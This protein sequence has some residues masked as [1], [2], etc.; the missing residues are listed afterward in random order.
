M[1]FTRNLARSIS[2]G[3]LAAFAACSVFEPPDAVDASA[4]GGAAGD[5]SV[6]VAS[7]GQAGSGGK[8]GSGGSS[9]GGAGGAG[10]GSG[11]VGGDAGPGGP[12][13]PRTTADGCESAG[14][15]KATDRPKASDPG[16][17]VGPIYLATSRMRFGSA[18]DDDALSADKDAWT[19]IGF[20]MDESCT[21][22]PTCSV[23]GGLVAEH[24]CKNSLL[25][26]FDGKQCRDNQ[27]GKLLPVA[28]LSPQVGPLFG[29]T[30]PNWNCAMHRGE[31]AVIFKVSDYNGKP[32]DA[33]VRLD[34]Y[35][36]T[37][38]QTMQNWTCTSGP[39]GTVPSDWYKQAPW[40]HTAH[41]KVAQR[42]VSFAAPDAGVEVPNSKYAD[43]AAF[44]RDGYLV[45]QLPAGTEYWLDGERAHVPGFRLQLH[46]AVLLGKLAKQLDGT[47]SLAGG[48][49][50]GV[51]LPTEILSA[52]REIGFCK[53]MCA[54]YD[55]VVGYL[56]TNQD[57]LSSTSDKLPGTPCDSLSIGIAFEARQATA[58]AADVEPVKDPVD[59]P[60]PKHP[61]APK[62][63]C[64]CPDPKVGGPC[65]FA[66]GGTDG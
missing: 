51:V 62:H 31:L 29:V 36:S 20:D 37:G 56:N 38:L 15:P 44:V 26:P 19:E 63:G 55:N 50:S 42:S 4:A 65:V 14:V 57:T 61:L 48:S 3:V 46:R 35:T 32:N 7:G 45:A 2:G 1:A 22:S 66:E 33:A 41:W 53:N 13:W 25:V 52:F 9:G 17:S 43:P 49:I 27:I 21:N 30:E 60:S 28:A 5:A 40:L 24:A 12:W 58:T 18:K 34:V 47:W 8:S 10:G 54:A 23:D 39:N 59:C 64:V 16:D 6:D 11:G